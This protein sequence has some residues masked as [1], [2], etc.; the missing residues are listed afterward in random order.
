MEKEKAIP[1][2]YMTVGE[3][4]KKMNVTVRTLQHYDNEG[5]LCPSSV[6]PGGRRLY[7][8]KD[9]LKL[10]QILSLKHLGFSLEDIHSRIIP[11][12]TPEEVA[13]ALAGQAAAIREKIEAMSESLRELE[14]LRDEVLQMQTVS[15][16]KY[17]DII[18]NLQ[19]K[20]DYYW[21]IKHFDDQTLDHIR[22]HFSADNGNSFMQKFLRMQERAVQ[23]KEAGVLPDSDQGIAFA[24]E[25][26]EMII[27][28][29]NGDA[30]MLE[31]LVELGQSDSSDPRMKKIQAECK[32]FIEPALEAYFIKIGVN[33]FQ[34]ETK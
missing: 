16:K 14:A 28:F 19:M 33:P 2:D 24:K 17:A 5:I 34:E 3:V 27:E 4:A 18:V 9:L 20:N 10:H 31:K 8:Y 32:A 12:D 13:D 30:A 1:K 29:T 25:Y 11:L 22:S 21:M 15:F 6:S 26:W 7:T 23:Y